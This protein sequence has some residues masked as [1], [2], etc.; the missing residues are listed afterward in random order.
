MANEKV[1]TIQ[2]TPRTGVDVILQIFGNLKKCDRL[3]NVFNEISRAGSQFHDVPPW[4]NL[5]FNFNLP[6][7]DENLQ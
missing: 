6:F 3:A 1:K 7:K 4:I 2:A 5:V